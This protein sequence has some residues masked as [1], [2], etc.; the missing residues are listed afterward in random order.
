MKRGL[1]TLLDLIENKYEILS[2]Y[3]GD[4]KDISV[5]C[6]NC[7]N[8]FITKPR[9]LKMNKGRTGKCKSCLTRGNSKKSEF[10]EYVNSVN[11]YEMVSE[12]IDNQKVTMKHI[13]CGH[14]WNIMP[15]YFKNRGQRCPKCFVKKRKKDKEFKEYVKLTKDYQL[16]SEY[17]TYHEDVKMKHLICG[18]EY[19]VKPSKFKHAKRRCPHCN[20]SNGELT[21]QSFLDENN[22]SYEREKKFND[23]TFKTSLRMDF[24]IHDFKMCIEFHGRQH[25]EYV[26][27]FH[28]TKENFLERIEKDRIKKEYC[29]N[30]DIKYIEISYNEFE[31]IKE[32][33]S[34]E[35]GITN[36]LNT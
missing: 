32:I 4:R 25:Y 27:W 19:Y 7:G 14:E 16:L 18:K 26:D 9:Y 31:K 10:I 12:Y 21:I 8:I 29:Q 13:E 34:K 28:K 1:K 15:H 35:L 23:M 17:K 2:E 3:N 22:I 33:L 5:K 11:G 24:Y 36:S 20:G 30:N 6:L